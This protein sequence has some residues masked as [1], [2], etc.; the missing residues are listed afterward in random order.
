MQLYRIW[1]TETGDNIMT[2]FGHNMKV[3]AVSVSPDGKRIPSGS[4]L[5]DRVWDVET[6]TELMTLPSDGVLAIAFSPDGRTIAGA[7]DPQAG[8]ISLCQSCT[9][10]TVNVTH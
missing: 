9:W 8:D 1:D 5:T 3:D 10:G 7:S 4:F 6:G 2:L